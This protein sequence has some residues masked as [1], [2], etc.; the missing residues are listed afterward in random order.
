[1]KKS[2]EISA[3]ASELRAMIGTLRRRLRERGGV[4]DL[5]PSQTDVLRQL[6]QQ[7]PATVSK[8]ARN[9][10]MRSQSMGAIVAVLEAEGLVRSSPDP[11]DGRQT[12]IALTQRAKDKIA[13]GRA[14]REDWLAQEIKQLS[15]DERA[16]LVAATAILRRIAGT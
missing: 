1:M 7:G 4:G 2:A 6:E 9:G 13:T 10:G 16:S 8:L 12:L 3:L 15:P 5:T 11:E 14:A